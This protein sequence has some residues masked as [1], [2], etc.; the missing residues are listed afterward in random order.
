MGFTIPRVDTLLAPYAEKSYKKYKEEYLNIKKDI[1]CYDNLDC[2][3][4]K[5][6][7]YAIKK[8]YRDLEQG[9]QSWEY[10]FNTVGSS[11]GDYPF[12][13]VS[14]GIDTTKFGRMITEQILKVRKGGQGKEGFKKPVLFPK[15]TFL[16]DKELHGEGKPMEYLFDLALQCSSKTMYPDFLSLTGEGYIP[17]IYKKYGKVISLMG[18]VDGEEVVTYTF[19]DILYVESFERMWKRLSDYYIQ[20][21]QIPNN[22]EYLYLDI[23]DNNVRIYDS[24]NGFV[25]VKK[26]IRNYNNNWVKVKFE[27]G[28]Q[29]LCTT[30]HP[31]PTQRGRVHAEDLTTDDTISINPEQYS[32][33]NI[34]FNTDKAWLLGMILCDGNYTNNI[35]IS[36]GCDETDI[37]ECCSYYMNKFFNIDVEVI[38]RNRGVKGHYIDIISKGNVSDIISYLTTKFEGINKIKRHIPTEV[39]SWNR[40]AKL[41]FLAGMIDADG[42]IN[43]KCSDGS[44]VQIGSVNKELSLQQMLLAQSL[45]MPAVMYEN[46]YNKNDSTKIRYKI[47]FTPSEELLNYIVS[48]K[49]RNNYKPKTTKTDDCS[50][51]EARVVSVE[52]FDI[53]QYS[54]DVE[55]ESDYFDV[56]GIYS[57]NCR[58]SLS[59]WYEKGGMKPEDDTDVPVFEGRFNL[60]AISLH[61]PMILAKSR[62]ENED[63][64]DT[65]HYYLE[66]IR[67]LH[68]RTFDF[69][70]EKLAST[71]PLGF[72]Q[73]GFYGGTLKPDEKIRPLLKPMTMSFGITALNELQ[74]LYNGKSLVEDGQFALEV[75]Q[76]INDYANKIKEE[77][78]ILYAIYGKNCCRV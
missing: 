70:G 4:D 20:K 38:E 39:F 55:T 49:K 8:I 40:E 11:R 12:I 30:D 43:P 53:N 66:M 25:K 78:G 1:V 48:D 22:K 76:Y 35:K 52:R 24:K 67:N 13:A 31:L 61:L 68:K 73:G 17:S 71:N 51:T 3:E 45:D 41:A 65:L 18:C 27:H 54:Y 77:D 26:V 69:L 16:Y 7:Q 50:Y 36:V 44:R 59:P 34:P 47:E 58:A 64:Y 56:S 19:R 37:E 2:E 5:A 72:T 14:F 57:H 28:R 23:T 46:H 6:E 29:L 60:G 21:E 42:Y 9:F 32:T 75:M 15:L 63:F 33:E 62:Q 74:E 10:R